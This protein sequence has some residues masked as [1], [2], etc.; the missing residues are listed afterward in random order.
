MREWFVLGCAVVLLLVSLSDWYGVS[1]RDAADPR[2]VWRDVATADA[3]RASTAWT[4]AVGVT[5]FAVALWLV[6][7]GQAV[8][9]VWAR[10]TAAVLVLAALGTVGWQYVA[11][12]EVDGVA[13]ASIAVSTAT[14]TG[15]AGSATLTYGV[16][17]T[18]YASQLTFDPPLDVVDRDDLVSGTAN[19]YRAGAR[20]G[21]TAGAALLA[22]ILL[23]LLTTPATAA[24]DRPRT[25]GRPGTDDPPGPG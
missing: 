3:W 7:R 19:G 5:A 2:S 16:P 14:R 18:A 9:P 24:A 15:G 22:V 12:G 13:P 8:Q 25:D 4:L 23:A 6:H 10:R 1:V 17:D 20:W 11:M 21:A